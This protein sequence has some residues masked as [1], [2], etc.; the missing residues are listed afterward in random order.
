MV[1]RLTGLNPLAYLGVEPLSPAQCFTNQPNNPTVNDYD[2]FELGAVWLVKDTN[3]IW[4]LVSKADF[5]ATWVQLGS[6]GSGLNTLTGN[7]GG[8]VSPTAGNIDVVGSGAI[9]VTGNPVTSTL[10]I[11]ASGSVATT[12]D[13]D[14]GSAT[15]AAGVLNVIG[16]D[17]ITTSGSGNTVTASVSGTTNHAVQIGN[18]S[19]SLSSLAVGTNGQVIIG[20]TGANPAFAAL[21]SIGGSIAFTP[22]ANSLNLEAIASGPLT[23]DAD[24][25]SASP[26]GGV[27]EVFGGD[28]ITTSA[29]GNTV[30]A[31]L[32]G[33]TEHAIPIGNAAGSLDSLVVGD[34][35]QV[36]IGATGADAEFATLTSSGGT[37]VFTPGPNALNLEAVLSSGSLI[38][39]ADSGTAS[40]SLGNLNVF[41]GDSITTSAVGDTITAAVTGCTQ[42]SPQ[43]GSASGALADIGVMTTGQVMVGVTGSAPNLTT[44]TAGTGISIDD[45]G[46][47]GEITISASGAGSGAVK[48]T[49]F[50]MSG[51]FTKDA[52]SKMIEYYIWS[53]GGGGGSGGRHSSIAGGGAGGGIIGYTVFT[54]PSIFVGATETVTI[55]AAGTGG[56]AITVD[57]TGGNT[58]TSGG[59][60][61]LGTTNIVPGG[62][63]IYP[64]S[65]SWGGRGGNIGSSPGTSLGGDAGM[66]AYYWSGSNGGLPSNIPGVLDAGGTGSVTAGASAPTCFAFGAPTGG[67]G[68]G[69]I[70]GVTATAGGNGGLVGNPSSVTSG[71]PVI[72]YGSAAAGG[73]AGVNGADG[74]DA[75]TNSPWMTGGFGAGGGGGHATA[76]GNGGEGGFPGGGGG[77]GGGVLN[78]NNSGAG[79]DGGDGQIIIIEYLG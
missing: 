9:T 75:L 22:G 18:A 32:S 55:G 38:I 11:T 19:A 2:N 28:N 77:G 8:A 54:L 62:W 60:S 44:L 39:T 64:V 73:A 5:I 41:G 58:G 14:S 40:P 21:T 6:G 13:C 53:A 67:G 34:D 16:G 37:I 63:A 78:G 57:N 25:G 74:A 59:H 43:M 4:I 7:S 49:T 66:A 56:A 68:A 35:G 61:E 71:F 69:G 3:A 70:N 48:V 52:G 23:I 10:T 17:N 36:L 50:T 51:T 76:P 20:A 33:I 72:T 79:G 47:P 24:S 46:S 12:I 26:M 45:T 31:S 27:L 1:K 15:P 42:Y 30:T 65:N 29:S